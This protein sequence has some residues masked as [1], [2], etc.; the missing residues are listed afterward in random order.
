MIRR[1]RDREIEIK[2][3]MNPHDDITRDG[4]GLL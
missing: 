3:K 4:E 1:K 2:R